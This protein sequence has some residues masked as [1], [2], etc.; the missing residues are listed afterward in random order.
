MSRRFSLAAAL[1]ALLMLSGCVVADGLAH[2]VKMS[3]SRKGAP[4]AATPAAQPEA[5]VP[6]EAAPPLGQQPPPRDV[7]KVEELPSVR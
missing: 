5:A 7:V 6:A 2:V 3:E 1:A 4:A